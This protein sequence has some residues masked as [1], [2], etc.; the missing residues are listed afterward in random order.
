LVLEGRL[1]TRAQLDRVDSMAPA[2]VLELLE[3]LEQLE[4]PVLLVQRVLLEQLDRVDAMA[5][6]LLLVLL[7]LLEPRVQLGR[8]DAME[9]AL[10]L[11]QLALRVLLDP[12]LQEIQAPLA[13]PV[14]PVQ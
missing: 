6:A 2:L 5:I 4:P 3:Q 13:L 9:I 11:E 1:V 10:L 8:V 14:R 12:W 7:V